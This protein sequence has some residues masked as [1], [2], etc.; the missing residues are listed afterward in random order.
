MNR[1]TPMRILAVP[2]ILAL[3]APPVGAL[4]EAPAENAA[5]VPVIRTP[6]DRSF[7]VVGRPVLLSAA[8]TDD[9]DPPELLTYRWNIE[10]T[11]R[12]HVVSQA[13]TETGASVSFRVDDLFEDEGFS[14]QIRLS[15]TDKEGL[16]GL[17]S[18]TIFPRVDREPTYPLGPNDVLK[19]TIY[20]GGE[21]QEEFSAEVS[22]SGTIT[23]PLLGDLVVS[24]STASEVSERLTSLLGRDYYVNPQVL[25]SVE[26]HSKKVFISGEVQKP[27]AYSIKDGAT[28]L[29][30]CILAGGFTDFAA[31]NRV[32]VTRTRRDSTFAIQVD[33]AKVQK[34]KARDLG[35]ETGDRV[36]IPHKRF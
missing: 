23:S 15:V 34:G 13:F 1:V 22:A 19:V 30:A 10:L 18:T 33:L 36:Q 32:V 12:E 6:A 4:P 5:P 14:L 9:R 29:N 28:V 16:T 8:A 31:L 11:N 25:V 20:A 35:L 24:G 7:F 2:L 27:G 26:Q 17:T 21:K 3:S